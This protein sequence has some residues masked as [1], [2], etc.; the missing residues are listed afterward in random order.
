MSPASAVAVTRSPGLL[1]E[2][3][4]H[5]DGLD[6][7]G[8]ARRDRRVSAA[9]FLEVFPDLDAWRS[10]NLAWR[11]AVGH[12]HDEYWTRKVEFGILRE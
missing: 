1:A 3:L 10:Y 7:S 5:V 4:A 9:R 8:R 2:Y 11:E 6:L 12:S